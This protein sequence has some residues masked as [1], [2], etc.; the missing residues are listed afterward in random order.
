M[1]PDFH[2]LDAFCD[3]ITGERRTGESAKVL[4]RVRYPEILESDKFKKTRQGLAA[5]I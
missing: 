4:P 2:L 1:L 3:F 5:G